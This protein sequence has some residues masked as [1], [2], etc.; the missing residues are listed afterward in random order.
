[1]DSRAPPPRAA[2]GDDD[3]DNEE[4]EEAEEEEEGGAVAALDIGGL[5]TGCAG[6]ISRVVRILTHCY[7]QR[8]RAVFR[9]TSAM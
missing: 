7:T 4:E 9:S 3:D 2:R 1:M 5:V 8:C 6:A